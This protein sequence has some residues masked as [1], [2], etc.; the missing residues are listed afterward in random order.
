MAGKHRGIQ[1]ALITALSKTDD[2]LTAR[3]L[4]SLLRSQGWRDLDKSAVNAFLYRKPS[5]FHK[6]D[7]SPPRWFLTD[8]D[9]PQDDS[10]A[11]PILQGIFASN[12]KSLGGPRLSVLRDINLFF[13]ANSSGKTSLLQSLLMLRQSWGS[14]QFVY[15]GDMASCENFLN[16]VHRHDPSLQVT[17][18]MC[19]SET[20]DELKEKAQL[21][22]HV[23]VE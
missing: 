5:Q 3:R 2:G 7:S 21:L 19:L 23:P 20:E 6:D 22:A 12:W 17:L 11:R 1:E 15:E 16:V 4:T 13:G 8:Q 10:D 18:G 9:L 14:P